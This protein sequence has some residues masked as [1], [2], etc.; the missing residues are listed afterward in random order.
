MQT[1]ILL[2]ALSPDQPTAYISGGTRLSDGSVPH[3][4]MVRTV[5]QIPGDRWRLAATAAR[6]WELLQQDVV[7]AGG[8]LVRL[9]DAWRD[10]ATQARKRA[11]YDLW[12]SHGRP[13][14]NK[15]GWQ[16]G[17]SVTYA[18]KPGQSGHGWGGSVDI[19]VGALL[20]PGCERGSNAALAKFWKLAAA[21][22]WHP[23]IANPSANQS[24]AWHFDHLG[25]LAVARHAFDEG[26]K[27]DHEMHGDEYAN[28]AR[29]GC[30]L[31]GTMPA[32]LV[33]DMNVAYIQ[34]RLALA[35]HYPGPIDGD[36]G[37]LTNAA[38]KAAGIAVP[39]WKKT[40]SNTVVQQVYNLNPEALAAA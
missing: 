12:T 18:S 32:T 6:D 35:G 30:V 10:Q 40:K 16:A 14:P 33:K 36:P 25:S 29:V 38:L 11:G 21:R 7:A 24:E 26:A 34:A 9:T 15:A 2:V 1:Q 20:F 5:G 22:G 31:A 13:V 27:T 8:E 19:D 3:L 17:M 23:I 37:D 4:S 28:T 39:D